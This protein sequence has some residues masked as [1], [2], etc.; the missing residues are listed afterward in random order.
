MEALKVNELTGHKGSIY[1]ICKSN[2]DHIVYTVGG[3]KKVIEW[4]LYDPQESKILVNLPVNSFAIYY[5][6]KFNLLIIGNINGGIHVIDLTIN[7][8]I[9]LLDFHKKAIFD[10]AFVEY[11]NELIVASE[12]GSFS[13]WSV[14]DFALIFKKSLT[15]KKIRSIS[16]NEITK[17]SVFTSNDLKVNVLNLEDYTTLFSMKLDEKE[18]FITSSLINNNDIIIGSRGY[19]SIFKEQELFMKISA[20]KFAIYDLVLSPNEKYLASC[21]LD[22]TIRIWDA[23]TYRLLKEINRSNEQ[24]HTNSVNKLLWTNYNDYLVSVS[25]DRLTMIWK[26]IEN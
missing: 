2:Q 10:F 16:I 20:H 6:K 19:L 11:K 13:I 9:K 14:P 21:S 25:D 5:I 17:V 26:I 3:D 7:Q 15:T 24:G 18:R 12:D 1:N 4:N 22:K 8:E 23:K